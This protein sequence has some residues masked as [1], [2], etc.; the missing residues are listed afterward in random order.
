MNHTWRISGR[1]IRGA[2]PR[3]YKAAWPCDNSSGILFTAGLHSNAIPTYLVVVV[4][5]VLLGDANPDANTDGNRRAHSNYNGDCLGV[6]FHLHSMTGMLIKRWRS[7]Q[8]CAE[9]RMMLHLLA[10]PCCASLTRAWTTSQASASTIQAIVIVVAVCVPSGPA[11]LS[12]R[13]HF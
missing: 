13:R 7:S 5:V 8:E 10:H 11:A 2:R 3:T 1:G 6:A 9:L 4:G 12:P